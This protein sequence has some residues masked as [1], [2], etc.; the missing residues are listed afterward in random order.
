MIVCQDVEPVSSNGIEDD[1]SNLR[2]L[3]ALPE[4]LLK[5]GDT[6]LVFR[7]QWLRTFVVGESA[8]RLR[9]VKDVGIDE[10]G[11]EHRATNV[12]VFRLQIDGQVFRQRNH[13]VPI[14]GKARSC[15]RR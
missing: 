7:R 11:T 3:H 6:L 14:T 13:A 15:C 5:H 10:T 12:R 8:G 4:D 9:T 1:L 2:W